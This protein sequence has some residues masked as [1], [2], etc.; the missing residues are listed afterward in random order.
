V[1][2]IINL[3]RQIFSYQGYV[4]T[5]HDLAKSRFIT[6][7]KII[8][9]RLRTCGSLAS[10]TAA[11]LRQLGYP[12]I[13]IDGRLTIDGKSIHHAWLEVVLVKPKR[14]L[15]IDPSRKPGKITKRYQ[16]RAA[17]LD[18][19]ELEKNKP[20]PR[21]TASHPRTKKSTSTG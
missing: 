6:I 3:V 18:W 5:T 13:L 7:K 8:E 17:Y 4:T 14:I 11:I 10:I 19:S 21:F 20:R 9:L 15:A 1:G 12:T 16:R 2:N